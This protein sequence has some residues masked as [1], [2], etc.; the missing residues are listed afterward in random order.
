M[1]KFYTKHQDIIE[2]TKGYLGVGLITL[3]G[4]T[5][6]HVINSVRYFMEMRWLF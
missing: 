1:R 2:L 5:G 6:W 4:C 3:D